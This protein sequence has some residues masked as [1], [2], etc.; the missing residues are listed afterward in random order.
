MIIYPHFCE[1]GSNNFATLITRNL[2]I[3]VRE[4]DRHDG[5]AIVGELNGEIPLV[6]FVNSNLVFITCSSSVV[7][8]MATNI[9]KI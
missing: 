4:N 1:T 9:P 2:T 7:M 8:R 5:G 3:F 6:E